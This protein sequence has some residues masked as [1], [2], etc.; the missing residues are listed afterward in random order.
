MFGCDMILSIKHNVDWELICQKKQAQTN[1]DNTRKNKNR[2]DH[3]YKV[4]D[5]VMLTKY[6]A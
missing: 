5:N 4:R 3:D 6:S 2:V 1:K